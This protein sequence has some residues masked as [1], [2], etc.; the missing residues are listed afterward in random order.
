M[1][2]GIIFAFLFGLALGSFLNVCIYRI[3]IKKSI[4]Y[5][6]SSC[7]RCEERIKFYDNIPVLSYLL[8]MG[9]CRRCGQPISIQYPMV[10]MAMGL[11][12]VA[13]LLKLG[14]TLEYVFFMLFVGSLIAMAFIDLRHKIVPD[15]ISLP[16]IVVGFALS[17]VPFTPLQWRDS[18]IGIV[19]GGGFLLMVAIFFEK[20]TGR[21]GMGMGDVKMLAMIGAWMG[22][23]ALP[24]VILLSSVA[25]SLIG[26]TFLIASRQG[27]KTKIPFGPFLSLG[28]MIYLFFGNELV[29]WF[30]QLGR[31]GGPF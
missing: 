12:S 26:G 3:P 7:P 17:L 23:Q 18:L 5:P 29:H 19:G 30:N 1:T 9:R 20:M 8:L 2:V 13:L 10:E 6:P 31:P 4:V 16:G 27:V 11:I 21:Q 25:G 14:P 24:F 15:V 22:W 28:A